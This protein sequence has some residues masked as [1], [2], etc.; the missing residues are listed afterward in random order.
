MWR[1]GVLLSAMGLLLAVGAV[2]LG[3]Q[4]MPTTFRVSAFVWVDLPLVLQVD[5]LPG[6]SQDARNAVLATSAS[7][8]KSPAV[9]AR[10][11]GKAAGLSAAQFKA[12]VTVSPVPN[13]TLLEFQARA[14]SA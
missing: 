12:D 11:A 5:P 6:P 3:L 4:A 10:A 14:S 7:E 2:L 8:A 9:L 1:R 13:A